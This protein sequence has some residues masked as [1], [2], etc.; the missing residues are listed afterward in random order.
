MENGSVHPDGLDDVWE[1]ALYCAK[2]ARLLRSFLDYLLKSQDAPEIKQAKL[3]EWRKHVGLQF[4]R[5]EFHEE[6]TAT[7]QKLRDSTIEERG[8]LIH[9]MLSNAQAQ[10]LEGADS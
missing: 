1:L 5:P 3:S 8:A 2:E 6:T 4:G 7:F 9:T 10:Y